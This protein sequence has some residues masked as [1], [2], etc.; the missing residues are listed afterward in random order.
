MIF[1]YVQLLWRHANKLKKIMDSFICWQ[2]KNT[3]ESSK[4]TGKIS[5]SFFKNHEKYNRKNK[6][7]KIFWNDRNAKMNSAKFSWDDRIAKINSANFIT[8]VVPNCK[9]KFKNFFRTYF[10]PSGTIT[11]LLIEETSKFS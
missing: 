11:R 10:L 9:N 5:Y 1:G 8:F 7:R 3:E 2:L 6:F 4:V